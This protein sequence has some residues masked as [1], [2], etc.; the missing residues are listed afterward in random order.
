MKTTPAPSTH[1]RHILCEEELTRVIRKTRCVYVFVRI[2]LDGPLTSALVVKKHAIEYI[3]LGYYRD[4]VA[5]V[6]DGGNLY[7]NSEVAPEWLVQR[8]KIATLTRRV[9]ELEQAIAA[10]DQRPDKTSLAISYL[11]SHRSDLAETRRQIHIA[12]GWFDRRHAQPV[13]A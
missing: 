3:R 8:R 7:L 2:E 10:L 9:A 4:F 1:P 5:R 12:Q 11:T 13:A 6:S